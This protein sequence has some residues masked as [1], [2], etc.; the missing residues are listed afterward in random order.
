MTD[1]AEEIPCKCCSPDADFRQFKE[2]RAFDEWDTTN[3][4]FGDARV[5]E[6]VECGRLWLRYFVEYEMISRSGRWAR[7]L[8]DPDTA[9]SITLENVTRYLDGLPH[10]I[11]GGSYFEKAEWSSE[12]VWWN[13]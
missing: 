7:G 4:R 6:C 1:A 10:L 11:R 13:M 8:I 5:D 3:G 2:W 9:G 12:P